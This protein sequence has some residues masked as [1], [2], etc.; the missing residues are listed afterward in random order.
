MQVNTYRMSGV[1]RDGAPSPRVWRIA[2]D[3]GVFWLAEDDGRSRLIAL[4]LPVGDGTDGAEQDE[5]GRAPWEALALA[6]ET[7][8]AARW[9]RKGAALPERDGAEHRP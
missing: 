6:A 8:A 2:T 1:R 7:E 3:E 5:S 9:V 4:P